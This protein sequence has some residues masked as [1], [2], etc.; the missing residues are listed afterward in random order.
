MFETLR[1]LKLYCRL[2]F[3]SRKGLS[4]VLNGIVIRNVKL[5]NIPYTV[6]YILNAI[7]SHPVNISVFNLLTQ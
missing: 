5:K 7:N 3:K 4:T 1:C 2:L 6:R